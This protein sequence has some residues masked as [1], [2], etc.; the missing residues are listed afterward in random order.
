MS[1]RRMWAARAG[2]GLL[3][4][5]ISA[6]TS[7]ASI[8]AAPTSAA[9]TSAGAPPASSADG[10]ILAG[11]AE[12]IIT[13]AVG[14]AAAPVPLAGFSEGRLAT[15]VR[16]DLSVR[17]LALE[18]GG[19]SVGIVTLDLYGLARAEVL[20]VR[21]A[22]QSRM[23]RIPVAGLLVVCSRTHASP[24][25]TGEFTQWQQVD[26]LYLAKVIE[27]AA[28][29]LAEAWQARQPARLSF[30]TTRLPRS[31]RDLRQPQRLDDQIMM[32]RLESAS[33]RVGIAT[34]VNFAGRPKSLGTDNT[35]V[36]ADYVSGLRAAL[37]R[38]FG[39]L[40]IFLLGAS[41]GELVPERDLGDEISRA[42]VVAW[43]GRQ[44]SGRALPSDLAS[45]VLQWK[46]Q[47][48]EIPVENA[49]LRARGLASAT[50][51][52]EVSLLTLAG[53]SGPA[54]EIACLPGELY[55]EL[56][57]GG[58]QDPQDPAADLPG[59]AREPALRSLLKSPVRMVASV[60][61]DDLGD[62]IPAAQWD[63][64]PPF[65]Y[66]LMSAQRGEAGSPGPRTAALLLR[67][68]ADLAR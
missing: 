35:L 54:L 18:A 38:A 12:R 50:L 34:V 23:P 45:A 11:A 61:N 37:E 32:M 31:L 40:A 9:P 64:R 4:L 46:T 63:T 21:A 58:I 33:G 19:R 39:G 3:L 59:A 62:L 1:A 47:T 2:A 24:D 13:P 25:L 44:E 14:G 67:A 15:G 10:P 30:A 51:T 29:A 6:S 17:A 66:S 49:A 53:R 65:A 5:A 48:V 28:E 42:L 41:G 22:V 68:F 36:S 16:D 43:S 57:N 56:A 20:R 8:S 26:D 52:T 7:A 60:C 27:A 55:P